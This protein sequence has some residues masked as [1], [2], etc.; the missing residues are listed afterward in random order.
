MTWKGQSN[1]AALAGRPVRVAFRL[2]AVK[3]YAFHF[4]NDA[5]ERLQ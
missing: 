2:R 3:L 1:V 5:G 4:V